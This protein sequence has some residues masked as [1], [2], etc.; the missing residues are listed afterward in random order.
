MESHLILWISISPCSCRRDLPTH[1]LLCERPEGLHEGLV[2]TALQQ[3]LLLLSVE[4]NPLRETSF[5]GS[6][7]KQPRVK[8][9]VLYCTTLPCLW[10]PSLQDSRLSHGY[11][12]SCPT[13]KF[14][15]WQSHPLVLTATGKQGFYRGQLT[16]S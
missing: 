8:A 15:C 4:H 3:Q 11:G 12:L 13:T 16:V 7:Q 10:F 2:L 6:A 1:S 5:V 14:L 9:T